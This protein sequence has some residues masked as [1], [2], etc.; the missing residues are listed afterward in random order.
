[1]RNGSLALAGGSFL[2]AM[3]LLTA[4]EDDDE[5]HKIHGFV[6]SNGD[7]VIPPRFDQVG[8]FA[9]GLAAAAAEGRWGYIDTRGVWV[10]EP[11]YLGAMPFSEGIAV[12]KVGTEK[13]SKE[14][15][16]DT[17]G[18]RLPGPDYAEALPF[19][20]GIA[21]VKSD[22]GWG[23]T[24]RQGEVVLEP[25]L[26]EIDTCPDAR[27][28]E[29][30]C[31]SG[32]LLAAKAG[33]LWGYLD[34]A[35]RWVIPP[36]F[37]RA[38]RFSEGLAAAGEKDSRVGYL[39]ARGDWIISPRFAD[40]LW[41]SR[42]RAIALRP[43]GETDQPGS[44]PAG[45][46]VL[47]DA[48]GQELATLDLGRDGSSKPHLSVEEGQL[49]SIADYFQSGLL[50]ARRKGQ[51]GYVD[52][53][54]NWMIEPQFDQAFPF[55]GGQAFV[56][57]SARPSDVPVAAGE[58][59]I[60]VIDLRGR[61]ILEPMYGEPILLGD[62]R[63]AIRT[64]RG[65]SVFGHDQR[66]IELGPGV[67]FNEDAILTAGP[68]TRADTGLYA[69]SVHA[70][71]R[72]T[73]LDRNG[74]EIAATE[75]D[76][77]Y[78][79]GKSPL[80]FRFGRDGLLGVADARLRE[81]LRPGFSSLEAHADG[82]LK[83]TAEGRTGC[84]DITGRPVVELQF[85]MIDLCRRNRIVAKQFGGGWGV[86][87]R[88]HGWVIA[89]E[90]EGVDELW[91][92]A[93]KV[94]RSG[95]LRVLM[96]P[97]QQSTV[98]VQF[99]K[100]FAAE[101]GSVGDIRIIKVGERS[102]T[103]DS[104]RYAILGPRAPAPDEFPFEQIE[105]FG[106]HPRPSESAEPVTAFK[107]RRNGVWGVIDT[108]GR[109]LLPIRYESI[110][111]AN[112]AGIAVRTGGKWGVIDTRGREIFPARYQLARPFTPD[113]VAFKES[114]LWGL[115]DRQGR[116]VVEPKYSTIDGQRVSTGKRS[117]RIDREGREVIAPQYEE[118]DEYSPLAWIAKDGERMLFIDKKDG[119]TLAEYSQLEVKGSGGDGLHAAKF[120]PDAGGPET[121]RFGYLDERGRIA[122][123]PRFD[124]AFPFQ[125]GRARVNVAGKCG[126]IDRAGREI[127]P[128]IHS[129]CLDLGDRLLVGIDLPFSDPERTRRHA[130]VAPGK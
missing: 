87:Q 104:D 14:G 23:L 41:F 50:P 80:R 120:A 93:Y 37:E 95:V 34:R 24:N 68:G 85:A 90:N 71:H 16:I 108:A 46:V 94:D 33:E 82:L 86:W 67:T 36:R 102:D 91:P 15:F 66:P 100:E 79:I 73:L 25:A 63:Y 115:A 22:A 70:M 28:H 45:N 39:D 32:G 78:P 44:Q 2:L 4:C 97:S 122:I 30:A 109:E 98:P 17:R 88:G 129:H 58:T 92:G 61:W 124:H 51:W 1:M 55:I 128:L 111:H 27:G 123:E 121:P 119:R 31:F 19:S 69:A 72:W 112:W 103:R 116:S 59:R 101:T 6:D 105:H 40:A 29:S 99:G 89:P 11:Q 65:D 13:E 53:D 9:E 107:V 118:I 35:G 110:G 7:W 47:I 8:P 56:S 60:G 113:L 38:R 20:G 83:V 114:E 125:D 84:V 57:M 62:G 106:F 18:T 96:L 48:S 12:V 127:V 49:L 54:G 77:A 26:A 76:S 81:I 64:P 43:D 5:R 117:G 42:G 75:S 3:G 10:I 21:A 52:R 130:D 74:R 126:F